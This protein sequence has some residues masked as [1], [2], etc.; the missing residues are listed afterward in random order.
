MTSKET[1]S[2]HS[3]T[4]PGTRHSTVPGSKRG[5]ESGVSSNQNAA[6]APGSGSK[7]AK[8]EKDFKDFRTIK[9]IIDESPHGRDA[10]KGQFCSYIDSLLDAMAAEYPLDRKSKTA[11]EGV[12]CTTWANDYARFLSQSARKPLV[13]L[14]SNPEYTGAPYEEVGKVI[15]RID[16]ELSKEP[17]KR[18]FGRLTSGAS[19]IAEACEDMTATLQK[20]E[21][22]KP[23]NSKRY[24]RVRFTEQ[25]QNNEGLI[26][27]H[28]KDPQWSARLETFK[29]SFQ[30][31]PPRRR[32]ERL[33]DKGSEGYEKALEGRCIGYLKR[34]HE[35]EYEFFTGNQET[36]FK[37]LYQEHQL[38]RQ[39][40]N[41]L[42]TDHASGREALKALLPP[43]VA[44]EDFVRLRD[45]FTKFIA[46][47][48]KYDDTKGV[49][50]H[51]KRIIKAEGEVDKKEGEEKAKAMKTLVELKAGLPDMIVKLLERRDKFL[52]DN[53][54]LAKLL[55]K[56]GKE[57]KNSSADSTEAGP[58]TVEWDPISG[59][60]EEWGVDDDNLIDIPWF[61][62]FQD[63]S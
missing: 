30:K 52:E 37:R 53:K 56:M 35:I 36:D 41:N 45:A 50:S 32:N 61:Q 31:F 19:T 33:P 40:K 55:D 42:S 7:R 24:W 13:A 63:G 6:P 46:S 20:F 59:P 26:K 1:D 44:S 28:E 16:E 27:Q 18:A 39:D 8:K 62:V 57:K 54:D 47:I 3:R 51:L 38:L 10:P 9:Q 43:N 11:S 22:A 17:V 5:S 12:K 21:A 23:K 15:L 34:M 2:Q 58:S 14:Q 48:S 60:L 29:S 25:Y 4:G 49:I